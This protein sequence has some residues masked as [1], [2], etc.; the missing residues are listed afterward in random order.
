MKSFIFGK[1]TY[2]DKIIMEYLKNTLKNC[3]YLGAKVDL[4]KITPDETN[5][6]VISNKSLY[7]IDQDKVLGYIKKDPTKPLM[8]L[9]KVRT[10]GT[11]FFGPHFEV[12]RITTNKAYNFAGMLF[13]PKRYFDALP[14][15]KRTVSQIFRS[16]PY[17][18]WRFYIINNKKK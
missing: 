12:D 3:E 10:F 13:L 15:N 1:H 8:V 4:S 7:Q 18:D 2:G 14:K 6:I 5:L 17:E 11:V 9:N 16:V